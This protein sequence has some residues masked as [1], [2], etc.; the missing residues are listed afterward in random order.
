MLSHVRLVR[1]CTR[2]TQ[3]LKT[4]KLID[5][6]L[7]HIAVKLEDRVCTPTE[8]RAQS[9]KREQIPFAS[10]RSTHRPTTRSCSTFIFN[11]K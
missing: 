4:H 6:K 2:A 5:K 3:N 11:Q 10:T 7:W 1:N 8:H 9:L